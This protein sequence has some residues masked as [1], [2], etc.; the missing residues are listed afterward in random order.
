MG[1]IILKKR[2]FILLLVAVLGVCFLSGCSTPSKVDESVKAQSGFNVLEENNCLAYNTDTLVIYYM[3]ISDGLNGRSYTYFAPY[4]SE[5]GSFCR[6]IDGQ[7]V[8]IANQT[9]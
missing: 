3:F 4:I 8:E 9:Q 7:I 5:N 6:Y 2:F 1:V